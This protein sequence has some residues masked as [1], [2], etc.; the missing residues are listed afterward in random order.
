MLSQ[1]LSGQTRNFALLLGGILLFLYL[2]PAILSFV[3]AQRR[4][5]AVLGL[6]V[7]LGPIQGLA[8]YGLAPYL[9]ATDTQVHI[10]RTMLLI[11]FGPGWLALMAWTLMPALPSPGLVAARASKTF[12]AIAA[13]PLILWFAYGILQVRPSLA[14]DMHLIAS[15]QGTVFA[16]AQ[17]FALTAAAAFDFLLI[18]VLLVRDKPRAKSQ[19]ALPR[20]CGFA[21]TF[22]GVGILQLPVA[23]LSPAMQIVAALVTG[24]GSLGSFVV[25]LWLGRSFSI[26]P[27]ARGLVT[28]GPY[29][30]ARH[31]LYT[32]EM[33]T[34][35]GTAMQFVQPWAA[36]LGAGVGALLV[37]RSVYEEQVLA[38]AFPEYDAYRV[39]TARFVPGVF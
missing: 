21:G 39:R 25:L 17:F 1:I 3:K 36:I 37:V 2:L 22:L 4:F 13:L 18:W 10:I 26:M 11:D 8:V 7:L 33:V 27:E 24:I 9:I 5:Y 32:V 28:G 31:P 16:W 29:A 30:W 23:A 20:L 19:G 34:V 35:V 14:R 6:N 38:A 12:D 15:G